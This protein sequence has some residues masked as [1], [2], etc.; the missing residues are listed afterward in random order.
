[1]AVK[2]TN[3]GLFSMPNGIQIKIPAELIHEDGVY[4]D[5]EVKENF[6]LS[7]VSFQRDFKGEC[8]YVVILTKHDQLSQLYITFSELYKARKMRWHL[9]TTKERVE[10]IDKVIVGFKE[11]SPTKADV[12][13]HLD[14]FCDSTNSNFIA[15]DVL[16]ILSK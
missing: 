12:K 16:F 3:S 7:N 10:A 15:D 2:K 5:S 9:M 1:M 13:A 4:Y 11:S 6:D 8:V 14:A